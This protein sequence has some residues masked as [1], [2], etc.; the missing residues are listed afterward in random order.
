MR[1][2]E[3]CRRPS[4]ARCSAR[5]LLVVRRSRRSRRC[6]GGSAL[7]RRMI[8]AFGSPRRP[9]RRF[10]DRSV[11]R[12]IA[13]LDH[14]AVVL[15][16]DEQD[17]GGAHEVRR[18]RKAQAPRH[19]AAPG[20]RRPQRQRL[21]S[22][23]RSRRPG[24]RSRTSVR[25]A[26]RRPRRGAR[27][28]PEARRR[29]ARSWRA[30]CPRPC[31]LR[32]ARPSGPTQNVT[33]SGG[34]R[35]HRSRSGRTSV[36][37]PVE[38]T[39]VAS[40]PMVRVWVNGPWSVRTDA[41]RPGDASEEIGGASGGLRAARGQQQGRCPEQASV[42]TA[43]SAARGLP[44]GARRGEARSGPRA[45]SRSRCPGLGEAPGAGQSRTSTFTNRPER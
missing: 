24:A 22:P 32:Y 19:R 6:R 28:G 44:T 10:V 11:H 7:M 33:S 16:L 31:A 15:P 21:R 37:V 29:C 13:E 30:A 2:R 3:R 36:S 14:R 23:R 43:S 34:A 41:A 5:P 45:S 26:E 12:Q 40:S 20:T 17:P 18:E 38:R 39:S 4:S 9:H 8:A 35:L 1:S 27:A 42:E 25:R